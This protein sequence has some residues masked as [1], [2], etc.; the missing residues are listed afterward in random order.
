MPEAHHSSASQEPD[1]PGRMPEQGDGTHRE[2]TVQNRLCGLQ[3]VREGMPERVDQS[4]GG[5]CADRRDDLHKMRRVR[6][7]LPDALHTQSLRRAAC[8]E[9]TTTEKR[10]DLLTDFRSFCLE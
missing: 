4:R 2:A 8:I 7:G 1:D 3:Q 10:T 9:D 6:G 5:S